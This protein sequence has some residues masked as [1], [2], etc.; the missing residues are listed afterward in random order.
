MKKIT[1]VLCSLVF[2]SSA[3]AQ[4][5]MMKKAW[6]EAEGT[7]KSYTDKVKT[8]CGATPKFAFDTKSFGT[9]L[10]QIQTASWCHEVVSA[11]A[12]LCSDADYKEAVKG[13]KAINCKYDPSIKKDSPDYGVS[14]V[15]KDGVVN[16]GFHKDSAN[17]Y[18]RSYEMLK[19]GL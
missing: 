17:L 7:V 6:S 3:F 15:V 9:S 2:A 10:D 5:V 18:S 13:I 4:S 16:F 1:L 14:L 8:D 19:A 11:V 12:A